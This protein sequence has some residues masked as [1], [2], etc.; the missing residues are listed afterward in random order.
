MDS[1]LARQVASTTRSVLQSQRLA[2][3]LRVEAAEQRARIAASRRRIQSSVAA[4]DRAAAVIALL[5]LTLDENHD[6]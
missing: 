2:Q 1:D 4:I 6:E 3:R 5:G